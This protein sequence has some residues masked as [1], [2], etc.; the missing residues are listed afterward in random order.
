MVRSTMSNASKRMGHYDVTRNESNARH[1][2]YV[3]QGQEA[4]DGI[5]TGID[6]DCG[7]SREAQELA[8]QYQHG[9][10]QTS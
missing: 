4:V 2:Q 9:Q 5:M 1:Q 7:V 3:E 6:P 10:L 8:L